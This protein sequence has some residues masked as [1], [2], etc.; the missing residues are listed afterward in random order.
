MGR[1]LRRFSL[2]EKKLTASMG[3][4]DTTSRRNQDCRYLVPDRSQCTLL[5]QRSSSPFPIIS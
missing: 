5:S 2:S 1:A 3:R 4:Q